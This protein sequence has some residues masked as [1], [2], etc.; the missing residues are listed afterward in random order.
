MSA[1]HACAAFRYAFLNLK[2]GSMTSRTSEAQVTIR[3]CWDDW[4]VL[5]ELE[6][7]FYN[8]IMYIYIYIEIDIQSYRYEY[9]WSYR[10]IYNRTISIFSKNKNKKMCHQYMF[11]VED[12]NLNR[13]IDASTTISGK[14]GQPNTSNTVVQYIN[15]C[16]CIY[17]HK[18]SRG[19]PLPGKHKISYH[20]FVRQPDG[21]FLGAP[22]VDGSCRCQLPGWHY[23]EVRGR[24][25]GSMVRINGLITYVQMGCLGLINH[26]IPNLL[27]SNFLGHPSI[28]FHLQEGQPNNLQ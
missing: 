3:C 17:V 21:W 1:N 15:L 7:L 13:R 4:V 23:L 18:N 24:K 5:G 10:Y 8:R 16:I 9:V 2:E 26:C 12:P 28:S 22:Q 27:L 19:R 25:W 14:W 20:C 11:L 6:W